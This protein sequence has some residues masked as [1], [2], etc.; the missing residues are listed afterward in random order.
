MAKPCFGQT[1][2]QGQGGVS[3]WNACCK[4]DLSAPPRLCA[5]KKGDSRGDAE[6]RRKGVPAAKPCFGQTE[7]QG[8]GGVRYGMPA[9]GAISLRLRVSA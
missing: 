5:N 2:R 3:A 9:A 6:P 7:R 8:Q 1:E 4:R